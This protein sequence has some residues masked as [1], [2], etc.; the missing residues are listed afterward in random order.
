MS[1]RDI[2]TQQQDGRAD[3]DFYIGTW[4]VRHRLRRTRLKGSE[5]WEEFDGR[6]VAHKVLDGLGNVDEITME[7]ASG[8]VVGM[9]VRLF[10]PRSQ[11]WS[12]YWADSVH[13]GLQPPM[14]GEF[15]EGRGL[16]YNQETLEGKPIFIRFIWS[17][18]AE[19]RC[20]WEQAFS[21]DGGS[22][23][24]TNWVMEFVHENTS[25]ACAR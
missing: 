22:T 12:I 8:R 2:T 15:K 18:L 17:S 25:S 4:K 6:A 10:D 3:F 11:Q 24:E 9:T 7:R 16:F 14:L 20:Q 1:E 21:A 5:E 13:G 19:S 23:W